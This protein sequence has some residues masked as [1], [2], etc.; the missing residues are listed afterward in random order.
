MVRADSE[1]NPVMLKGFRDPYLNTSQTISHVSNPQSSPSSLLIIGSGLWYLRNPSSGGLAAWGSKIHDTFEHLKERQGSPGTALMTP[2]DD[3][4]LGSGVTFPGFLPSAGV[5]ERSFPSISSSE[6]ALSAR[7]LGRRAENFAIADAV[8]FLPIVDPVAAKL[9]APRAET[10]MHTDVE[11]MNADLYAR[12]THPDPPPVVIPSVF[13]QLL[14]ESET[15]DGLHYSDRMM[16]KQ[17]ELLFAWRCNDAVRKDSIHGACCTRYDWVRPVQALL[18]ILLGIW[19][20]L[21]SLIAPRL[22]KSH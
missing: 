6:G 16:D 22:R 19:A 9:S 18:V 15:E 11:A 20:P 21:G 13:N 12:L 3:M 2:W 8:I 5:S 14:V 7:S 1:S 17:A 10:I 4:K